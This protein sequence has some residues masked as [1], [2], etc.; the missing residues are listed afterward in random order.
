MSLF[1]FIF[2]IQGFLLL[3]F[4]FFLFLFTFRDYSRWKSTNAQD[5]LNTT[6]TTTVVNNVSLVHYILVTPFAAF[7]VIVR[8]LFDTVRYGLYYSL[9]Y[10]EK[11]WPQIDDWLFETITIRLP[12]RLEQLETYWTEIGRPTILSYQARFLK[13][14]LP[15]SAEV[16]EVVCLRIYQFGCAV[17]RLLVAMAV[18]WRR[19]VESHD[20]QRL[21]KDMGEA[22]EG[23]AINL[24]RLGELGYRGCH[25]AI[26]SIKAD[27]IW[28]ASWVLPILDWLFIVGEWMAVRLEVM[29]GPMLWI[30]DTLV[31]PT[32]GRALVVCLKTIDRLLLMVQRNSHLLERIYRFLAPHLVWICLDFWKMGTDLWALT[33]K[34]FKEI[35]P[36]F[37]LFLKHL[38]PR[39]S[40]AYRKLRERLWCLLA[41]IWNLV[42]PYLQRLCGPVVYG[43]QIACI[44]VV[45]WLW[46]C[47][48]TLQAVAARCL[49]MATCC[50]RWIYSM[51]Q[52]WLARQAPVLSRLL[53]Q[54]YDYDWQG[55]NQ[56]IMSM[57]LVTYQWVSDQLQLIYSSLER[58]LVGWANEKKE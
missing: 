12:R 39:L 3:L 15:R 52:Q 26:M 24:W 5:T 49:V 14:W 44:E 7:Y 8:L 41:P 38:L 53:Q 30:R 4:L 43:I 2:S 16:V 58:S 51:S 45:G 17:Q 56:V 40:V 28:L 1:G 36:A 25:Q 29:V 10:L 47:L 57:I 34:A 6:T 31:A 23:I 32:L 11:S 55:C 33:K 37:G 21:A 18:V 9:W 42:V 20:W 22:L 46:L 19:F 35:E 48:P 54:I 27:I 13:H 50:A